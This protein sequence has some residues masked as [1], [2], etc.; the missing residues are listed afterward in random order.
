MSRYA[1]I[2][3][4][5]CRFVSIGRGERAS[6]SQNLATKKQKLIS[7]SFVVI[8]PPT[9]IHRDGKM[10]E[11][12]REGKEWG[13]EWGKEQTSV[14]PG[15]SVNFVGLSNDS[16][17]CKLLNE[18]LNWWNM[19]DHR[20]IQISEDWERYVKSLSHAKLLEPLESYVA[21]AR[22]TRLLELGTSKDHPGSYEC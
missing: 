17:L 16:I 3:A 7:L 1:P 12:R 22:S 9:H 15:L 11:V 6:S 8:A 4:G 2:W 13:R 20:G 5:R 21:G 14:V 19:V 18:H 10:G